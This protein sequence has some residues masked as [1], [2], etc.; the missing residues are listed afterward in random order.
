MFATFTPTPLFFAFSA[1]VFFAAEKLKQSPRSQ[2]LSVQL[3]NK[4]SMVAT[5]ALIFRYYYIRQPWYMVKHDPETNTTE[6]QE[7]RSNIEEL[8][9]TY[10][11]CVR[12]G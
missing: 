9:T 7:R 12:E 4:I 3:T 1:W 6:L 8:K 2:F 11:E 10:D 5:T